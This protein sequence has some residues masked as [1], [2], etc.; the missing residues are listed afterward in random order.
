M[1]LAWCPVVLLLWSNAVLQVSSSHFGRTTT[2][3]TSG[4]R[5]GSHS[6]VNNQYRRHGDEEGEEDSFGHHGVDARS[7]YISDFRPYVPSNRVVKEIKSSPLRSFRKVEPER[8]RQV[9]S[10]VT[11]DSNSER[12]RRHSLPKLSAWDMS[13]QEVKFAPKE[14]H[15][16]SQ[17]PKRSSRFQPKQ[18]I[19]RSPSS[20]DDHAQASGEKEWDGEGR[21]YFPRQKQQ[22]RQLEARTGSAQNSQRKKSVPFH[23][24]FDA[25]QE[26][27]KQLEQAEFYVEPEGEEPSEFE[28]E[29]QHQFLILDQRKPSVQRKPFFASDVDSLTFGHSQGSRSAS[30]TEQRKFELD[31]ESVKLAKELE[32]KNRQS[33][34]ENEMKQRAKKEAEK[35]AEKQ[36]KAKKEA[37][38]AKEQ[39][40]YLDQET[41]SIHE[42]EQE[43]LAQITKVDEEKRVLEN[44][45]KDLR[46]KLRTLQ[47]SKY[48]Q[49]PDG[50]PTSVPSLPV[51]SSRPCALL[52][53][54][55]PQPIARMGSSA[56]ISEEEI[57]DAPPM[58]PVPKDTVSAQKS[59]TQ[60]KA[61]AQKKSSKEHEAA[62]QQ[63][64]V[65]RELKKQK[66]TQSF[67]LPLY[68]N[69]RSAKDD[70][71]QASSTSSSSSSRPHPSAQA[72]KPNTSQPK[73]THTLPST[74]SPSQR[75]SLGDGGETQQASSY[76][77][78]P[79]TTS[80]QSKKGF[81]ILTYAPSASSH[82]KPQSRKTST[83]EESSQSPGR[84]RAWACAFF[85]FLLINSIAFKFNFEY[86][87]FKMERVDL[88]GALSLKVGWNA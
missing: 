67:S 60:I 63:S 84:W 38:K 40:V 47:Q 10:K 57:P 83:S 50:Y 39:Q 88:S 18:P 8:A 72:V 25:P 77:T 61:K 45:L 11:R 17:A 44:R 69:Q 86:L 22:S 36:Q 33:D 28:R 56:K 70:S 5:A 68:N 46:L 6:V 9:G 41:E 80:D 65:T 74:P 4:V 62:L 20:G 27:P 32:E 14:K 75:V 35:E 29:Q 26:I 42:Q 1:I 23:S 3:R 78:L 7:S 49:Q 21:P 37:E 64:I 2:T 71:K 31:Y 30:K 59:L 16:E 55:A 87:H 81:P 19:A 54:S 73:A 85:Q 43:L 48:E 24:T 34:L 52:S 58:D 66:Q 15:E 53:V 82:S 79:S 51:L 12:Q 13:T 76:Q